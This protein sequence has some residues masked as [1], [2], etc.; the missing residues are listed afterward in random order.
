M[1]RIFLLMWFTLLS[2]SLYA[3]QEAEGRVGIGTSSPKA[4][5]DILENA[6]LP[7]AQAQGVTFPNFSTDERAKFRD[8]KVGTMIFNTTKQCLEMYYGLKEG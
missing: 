2:V 7:E 5:L 1:K 6:S 8:V 4:T 3:Q